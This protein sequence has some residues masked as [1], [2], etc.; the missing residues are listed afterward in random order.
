MLSIP[1]PLNT[2]YQPLPSSL[3]IPGSSKGLLLCILT[4]YPRYHY[5][6]SIPINK[7]YTG[8]WIPQHVVIPRLKVVNRYSIAPDSYLVRHQNPL[9]PY[10]SPNTQYPSIYLFPV[11]CLLFPITCL[12]S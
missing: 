11:P 7:D 1:L 6:T 8:Y 2:S 4:G 3:Y 10:P 12:L 9:Y 5:I